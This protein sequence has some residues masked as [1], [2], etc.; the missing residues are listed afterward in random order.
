MKKFFTA[1]LVAMG[2]FLF[3]AGASAQMKIGYI[4]VDNMVALMPE[5]AKLD[6]LMDKYQVDSLNPQYAYIVSEYQRKDSLFRDSLKT[7]QSVRKQIA[8]ELPGL[9][10]QIQNW[11]AIV[12]Q[13]SENKQNEL[14]SPIYRKVY[15]AIKAVAKEKGYTHVYN[16]EA[17]LV[18]P[19]G[20]D[21][22]AIV[23]QKL[24]VTLPKPKPGGN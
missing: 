2:L 20:D 1:V 21:M 17:L 18:A 8:E 7:P 24:K 10:Y 16:K 11:Q 22:L 3:S 9:I 6:S 5:T 13:A 4:S 23:A 12:Q 14:L 19:D 15:D